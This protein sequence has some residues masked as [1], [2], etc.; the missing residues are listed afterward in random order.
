MYYIRH[1]LL[2]P[3]Y[4]LV[5][6]LYALHHSLS[7][8]RLYRWALGGHWEHWQLGDPVNGTIWE[9]IPRDKCYRLTGER[10]CSLHRGSAYCEE[11]GEAAYG[12][13]VYCKCGRDLSRAPGVHGAYEGDPDTSAVYGYSCPCGRWP[14]FVSGLG[15]QYIG[16][17]NEESN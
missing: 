4:V 17:A 13:A 2:L 14:R 7:Y 12:S 5:I 16:D 15:W 11:R 6:P 9:R 3:F 8:L 10:T 1:I